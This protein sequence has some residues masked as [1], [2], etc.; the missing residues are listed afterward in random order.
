[1]VN[2]VHRRYTFT[3]PEKHFASD[4]AEYAS[5][6]GKM[7]LSEPHF[8]EKTGKVPYFLTKF[9]S[10]QSFVRKMKGVPCCRRRFW[11]PSGQTFGLNVNRVTQAV[12]NSP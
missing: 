5:L 11:L 9:C 3:K 10:Q 8:S 12:H 2:V 4:R 6:F 7:G 1:M